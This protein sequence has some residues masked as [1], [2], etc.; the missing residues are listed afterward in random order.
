MNRFLR[1][2]ALACGIVNMACL[3]SAGVS[4]P[5]LDVFYINSGLTRHQVI[6][7][8]GFTQTTGHLLKILYFESFWGWPAKPAGNCRSGNLPPPCRSHSPESTGSGISMM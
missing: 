1:S 8:K 5:I 7:I 2:G 3:L 4:G 6:A